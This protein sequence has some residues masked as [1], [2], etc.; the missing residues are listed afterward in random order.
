[1]SAIANNAPRSPS[2]LAVVVSSVV[3]SLSASRSAK[4]LKD[5][6]SIT[7]EFNLNK[8]LPRWPAECQ[9]EPKQIGKKNIFKAL[10]FSTRF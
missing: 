3:P 5:L 7:K 10:Y 2:S 1:M 6:Y 4:S 9:V 8:C